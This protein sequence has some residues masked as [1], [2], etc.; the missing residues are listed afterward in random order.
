MKDTK[1][2][3]NGFSA[4]GYGNKALIN[5]DTGAVIKYIV[6]EGKNITA[7]QMLQV[8]LELNGKH[9]VD[10]TGDDLR[11]ID[12]YKSKF[13]DATRWVIPFADLSAKT[14]QGLELSGLVT[15]ANDNLVLKVKIGA[16]EMPAQDGL[17]PQ[18]NGYIVQ[19]GRQI[20]NGVLEPRVNIPKIYGENIPAGASG[21]NH[22][23]TFPRGRFIRRIHMRD[24]AVDELEI[25]HNSLTKFELT[26][27][28]N[29]FE[30]KRYGMTPQA[31][32]FHF[33][34]IATGWAAYDIFDTSGDSLDIIMTLSEAG[35][36]YA[37]FET[38]EPVAMA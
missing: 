6:I 12:K 36:V 4:V 23:K 21:E 34:P 15:L 24:S 37:V 22:F 18:L 32:V 19:R 14:Q 28:E 3:L 7:A 25:V 11:M 8:Q 16:R 31:D 30:I 1:L 20:I 27:A 13:Q 29:E 5:L 38:L 26:K 2:K 33:D 10:V 17:T 9:I 35:D